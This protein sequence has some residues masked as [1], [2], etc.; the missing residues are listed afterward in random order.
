MSEL[1]E[2]LGELNITGNVL[3]RRFGSQELAAGLPENTTFQRLDPS[4]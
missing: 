1:C 4:N 2:R 3:V